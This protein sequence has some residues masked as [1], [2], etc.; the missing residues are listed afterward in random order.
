MPIKALVFDCGGVVLRDRDESYYARWE[1]RLGLDAGVLKQE[2]Y[3]GFLW[4]EAELGKISEDQFWRSAGE[5]YG[6]SPAESDALGADAWKSWGVDPVVLSLVKRARGRFRIAMLSNATDALE[7]KLSAIYGIADLFDPIVNSSRLGIA[8]PAPEIYQ[9]LLKRMGLEA[10]ETVFIDDRADNV[11]AAAS[12]GMHVIWFVHP[13][14]L[15]RQLSPYLALESVA[16][17][18]P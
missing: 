18:S 3:Q 6:L 17:E 1:Q 13:N 7:S 8:K 11:A 9:E 16:I 14:E 15:E 2:L 12:L 4:S 5:R 10:G